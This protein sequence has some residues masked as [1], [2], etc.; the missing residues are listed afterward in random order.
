VHATGEWSWFA[1][2]DRLGIDA[3]TKGGAALHLADMS[4]VMSAAVN[5][6]GVALVRSLLAHEALRAGTLVVPIAEFE[7]M[8][9]IKKHVARWRCSEADDLGIG[10]FVDWLAMEAKTT[11]S[12]VQG[13]LPG[14]PPKLQL[15]VVGKGG[16]H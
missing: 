8:P 5:G 13:F 14:S 4:L 1:W 15:A 10:A 7:P 9:S 2:F 12:N 16:G 6:A 3:G 11:L